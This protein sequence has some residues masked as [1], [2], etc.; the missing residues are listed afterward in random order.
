[1]TRA[2]SNATEYSDIVVIPLDKA[3]ISSTSEINGP[4]KMA[5]TPARTHTSVPRSHYRL[6]PVLEAVELESD[7][8]ESSFPNP[9]VG[10]SVRQPLKRNK[11]TKELISRFESLE[12]TSSVPQTPKTKQP[13]KRYSLAI[14]QDSM[15]SKDKNITN[16]KLANRSPLRRSFGNLL[17]IFGRKSKAP[18]KDDDNLLLTHYQPKLSQP[19][20][21]AKP[22]VDHPITSPLHSGLLLYLS[23]PPTSDGTC[24]PIW[25]DCITTLYS[26][27]IHITWKT[28]QG[29][30]HPHSRAIQLGPCID[31]HSVALDELNSDE[32]A[33]LPTRELKVFELLFKERPKEKFVAASVQERAGWI[34]AIW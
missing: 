15:I 26:T 33:L 14:K 28:S 4:R 21:K 10:S 19:V 9:H 27:H 20:K 31:V 30:P 13:Q 23:P 11:S 3:P 18:T 5:L 24:L 25:T 2:S 16:N 7:H 6:D 22:N 17:A 1:M 12:G 34:S 32:I 29:N 8:Q